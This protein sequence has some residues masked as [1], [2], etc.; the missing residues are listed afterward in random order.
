MNTSWR[1]LTS[2][3]LNGHT[4]VIEQIDDESL[5]D[6]LVAF[7]RDLVIIP[8]T[9]CRVDERQRCY[10]SVRNHIDSIESVKIREFSSE[11]YPSL[12]ALPQ[13]CVEPDVLLCAHLDVVALPDDSDYRSKIVDGR[14]VGP[15]AGDMK[16]QLAILLELFHAFHHQHPG[17]SLGLAV[18][19]DEEIGGVHGIGY[20]ADEIG[21]RCGVAIIPDGGA[22]DEV[23]VEEKGILH[24]C[25]SAKGHAG[26]GARPWRAQNALE[27]LMDSLASIRQHFDTLSDDSSDH[28]HPTCSVNVVHVE[29][30][31]V[32]RIPP[33]AEAMLD[34]RF[35]PPHTMDSMFAQIQKLV[36]ERVKAEMVMGGQPTHL[37]P[38]QA[39]LDVVQEL[40]GETP[41]MIRESGGSDARF[42]C[43]HGIPVI[44]ARPDV[45][46]LH[47][48]DEWIDIDSMVLFYR[49]CER[50]L[51]RRLL[52]KLPPQ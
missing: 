47:A 20:L 52:K 1:L 14:I 15:G 12:V 4:T 24:M 5:K 26:H 23:T 21:L 27:I 11:G 35:P 19:S 13:G 16:G 28:W 31:T 18:T 7:T 9:A 40:T 34:I 49:V 37:A 3:P 48:E 45:G 39:Y 17:V 22:M 33:K 25:V 51:E 8:S 44:M 29:N 36:G 10:E 42:L 2:C 41:R 6:R 30:D 50:Y 43:R 32:N 38:D 46:E